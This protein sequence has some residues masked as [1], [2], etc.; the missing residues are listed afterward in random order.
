MRPLTG[1]PM[2]AFCGAT[3]VPG[4]GAETVVVVVLLL[5][6]VVLLLVTVMLSA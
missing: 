6:T 3:L 5:V 1:L 4:T 2:G